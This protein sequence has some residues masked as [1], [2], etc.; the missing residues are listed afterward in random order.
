MTT[1]HDQDCISLE[2]VTPAGP[3]FKGSVH[4]FTLP[5]A[6]GRIGVLRNHAPLICVVEPGPLRY[7]SNAGAGQVDVGKGFA[8]LHENKAVIL[9]DAAKRVE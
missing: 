6:L 4:S 2:V 7:E 8:E 3:V 1:S 9:V 5:T